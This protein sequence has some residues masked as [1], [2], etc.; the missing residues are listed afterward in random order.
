MM[1]EDAQAAVTHP[2][3]QEAV[4]EILPLVQKNAVMKYPFG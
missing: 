1:E 3:A 4:Q 2:T